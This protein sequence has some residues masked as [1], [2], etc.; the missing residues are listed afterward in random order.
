MPIES[1]PSCD[2]PF[3][4]IKDFPKVY[5][6]NVA[7]EATPEDT[8]FPLSF[9]SAG[10]FVDPEKKRQGMGNRSVPVAVMELFAGHPETKRDVVDYHGWQWTRNFSGYIDTRTS[11]F[12][13]HRTYSYD[14]SNNDQ[15]GLIK[16][17]VLLRL[18]K[19]LGRLE[20]Q[21][22]QEV[23]RDIL[24]PPHL[25]GGYRAEFNWG[26]GEVDEATGLNRVNLSVNYHTGGSIYTAKPIVQV[27]TIDYEGRLNH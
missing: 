18:N 8:R 27:A 23:P 5:L 20:E 15:T 1:C 3:Q 11:P 26:L 19:Y 17:I 16:N 24:T 7:R 6:A 10:V 4:S 22:G 12:T 21:V 13:D 14:L 2:R 9:R 25:L